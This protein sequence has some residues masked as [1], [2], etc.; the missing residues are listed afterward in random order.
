[1]EIFSVL[2]FAIVGSPSAFPSSKWYHGK[3]VFGKNNGADIEWMDGWWTIME[4]LA[5]NKLA[6]E[7]CDKEMDGR[8]SS[9]DPF[10]LFL[11]SASLWLANHRAVVALSLVMWK[12]NEWKWIFNPAGGRKLSGFKL[13]SMKEKPCWLVQIAFSTLIE[14]HVSCRCLPHDEHGNILPRLRLKKH[15]DVNFW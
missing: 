7:I 15:R 8:Q 3:K 14:F 4:N 2:I 10:N 6:K 5:M 9:S 1:M 11:F 13:F 12:I